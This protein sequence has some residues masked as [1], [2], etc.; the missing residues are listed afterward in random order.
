[1]PSLT[2]H[3]HVS[4]LK[5][6]IADPRGHGK[7]TSESVCLMLLD[8]KHIYLQLAAHVICIDHHIC[9]KIW[10][11]NNF[12]RDA[13]MAADWR[14]DEISNPAEAYTSETRPRYHMSIQ[15]WARKV[16]DLWRVLVG[17]RCHKDVQ[18]PHKNIC[19]KHHR[20]LSWRKRGISHP[21]FRARENDTI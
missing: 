21:S 6:V 13:H 3:D 19:S 20:S 9:S 16:A 8:Q 2:V 10:L 4:H 7:T 11:Q 15:K 1:M 17:H 14:R 12:N 5:H 18:S